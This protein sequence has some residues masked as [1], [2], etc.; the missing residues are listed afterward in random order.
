METGKV[1]KLARKK[2]GKTQS[3]IAQSCYV[4]DAV[5]SNYENGKSAPDLAMILKLCNALNVTP[6]ELKTGTLSDDPNKELPPENLDK[7]LLATTLKEFRICAGISQTDE[8]TQVFVTPQTVSKWESGATLP[9]FENLCRLSDL[10]AVNTTLFFTGAKRKTETISDGAQNVTYKKTAKTA[11][12]MAAIFAALFVFSLAATAIL[13][14]GYVKAR[15]S[16]KAD[17]AYLEDISAKDEKIN[18]LEKTKYE[19]RVENERLTEKIS[20][21]TTAESNLAELKEKLDESK[22]TADRLQ[23]E[24]NALQAE[25]EQVKSDNQATADEKNARIADLETDITELNKQI[26]AVKD[27][28]ERKVLTLTLNYPSSSETFYLLS[29]VTT[30]VTPSFEKSPYCRFCE[31]ENGDGFSVDSGDF[32]IKI[33]SNLTLYAVYQAKWVDFSLASTDEER[34]L[35]TQVENDLIAIEQSRFRNISFCLQD[36]VMDSFFSKGNNDGYDYVINYL[37][38]AKETNGTYVCFFSEELRKTEKLLGGNTAFATLSSRLLTTADN[39]DKFIKTVI[40]TYY[41]PVTIPDDLYG[42]AKIN[43]FVENCIKPRTE[44]L[45]PDYREVYKS[46]YG[47]TSLKNVRCDVLDHDSALNAFH[48]NYMDWLIENGYWY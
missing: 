40:E 15:N 39:C 9:S 33:N 29:G 46:F 6:E 22:Q 7:Q 37:R 1:L 34:E 24:A 41:P 42:T 21:L 12:V 16:L 28:A 18:E 10:Y 36:C 45:I 3:E 31:Y 20:E 14:V 4:V 13:T 38:I 2:Q 11:S 5:I 25:L 27:L 26:E 23:R 30:T 8:A 47:L 17:E 32:T 48:E 35:L 19:L 44:A 43:Y